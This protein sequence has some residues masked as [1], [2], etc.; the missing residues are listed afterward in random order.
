MSTVVDPGTALNSRYNRR[1]KV[2]RLPIEAISQASANQRAGRCGRV[3]PG[4]CVRPYSEEDFA[5]R[6]EFTDPEILRTTLASV[7]LQ[8]PALGLDDSVRLE[9]RRVG[10]EGGTKC[11]SRRPQ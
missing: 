6:P 1:T 9:E 11:R 3:A 8:M 2:Q 5:S 4:T 7:I 10:T